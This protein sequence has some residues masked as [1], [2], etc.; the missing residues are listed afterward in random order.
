MADGRRHG[1]A[2]DDAGSGTASNRRHTGGRQRHDDQSASDGRTRRGLLKTLGA[3]GGG[4]LV[5]S[6][7]V[8]DR[9]RAAVGTAPRSVVTSSHVL[10]EE[11]ADLD[12]WRVLNEAFGQQSAYSFAGDASLGI[13]ARDLD[14][15]VAVY[16]PDELADG[17]RLDSF[18]VHWL[19]TSAS[20]GGGLRFFDAD[21]NVVCG[22]ATDNP[23][24][25]V[26]HG[27]PNNQ[28]AVGRTETRYESWVQTTL[29]FDWA[30]GTFEITFTNTD[31]PDNEVTETFDLVTATNVA[32][33]EVQN[34]ASTVSRKSGWTGRDTSD[35]YEFS[36]QMFFDAMR[37]TLPRTDDADGDT[38]DEDTDDESGVERIVRVNTDG[39]EYQ[40]GRVVSP[41]AELTPGSTAE[42][43][44]SVDALI[45]DAR[46]NIVYGA[47]GSGDGDL[48]G[49]AQMPG[50]GSGTVT[51]DATIPDDATGEAY[52]TWVP[53]VTDSEA[54]EK[55]RQSL[56][57]KRGDTLPA[58]SGLSNDGVIAYSLGAVDGSTDGTD[59]E[60]SSEE[61][62]TDGP[63][64][65]VETVSV[66]VESR[67]TAAVR[68]EGFD[69]GFSGADVTI[70]FPAV[71]RPTGATAAEAF[72][73]TEA[74][75]DGQTAQL[76]V[77]D[78]SDSF[79]PDDDA[80]TLGEITLQGVAAGRGR[81]EIVDQSVDSDAGEAVPVT[82]AADCG[83][84]TAT[85]AAC[86]TVD[87]TTTTDS[88][89]DGRCEDFNGNGR[90]DFDDVTTFFE[91]VD[92]A[93]VDENPSAFDFNGNGR[94]DFDDI[95]ALFDEVS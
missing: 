16:E 63:T 70:R 45:P 77:A 52:W 69:P 1:V 5:A 40:S 32:T 80:F 87:G 47:V 39:E 56:S 66:G 82:L 28:T 78:L 17:R 64:L 34:F 26:E 55:A 51:V 4:S 15:R 22:F 21:G 29:S 44:I 74:S 57:A 30:A 3:V 71:V 8:A 7:G 20:F 68:L 53:A 81:V 73:T 13:A 88:D 25:Y 2:G 83:D 46:D 43:T 54:R 35:Y 23:E 37:T 72:G 10:T 93:A 60:E 95:R 65:C 58:S 9:G 41:P 14:Q 49:L 38:D 11:G 27:A 91:N 85:E 6:A 90:A 50:T 75:V 12:D 19:E 59:D 31:D 67:T 61:E 94:I 42:L 84:V 92:A 86:P 62:S 79:G 48:Y 36:M 24:W 18:D 76:R 33:V 89:G